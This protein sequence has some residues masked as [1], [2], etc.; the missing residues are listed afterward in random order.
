MRSKYP[1]I[2][3]RSASNSRKENL[4]AAY[5]TH[6]QIALSL[7][8]LHLPHLTSLN[9]STTRSRNPTSLPSAAL[10]SSRLAIRCVFRGPFLL[11]CWE[12]S[13]GDVIK[14][15]FM[16]E[17]LGENETSPKDDGEEEIAGGEENLSPAIHPVG[18][19]HQTLL[20]QRRQR[21]SAVAAR[22]GIETWRIH[23]N[24]ILRERTKLSQTQAWIKVE[25]LTFSTF[26]TVVH[27]KMILFFPHLAP[28]RSSFTGL[29]RHHI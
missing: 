24:F 1:P 11:P 7:L 2:C 27:L 16:S 14:R 5:V 23:R 4:T 9:P 20:R 29:R 3:M 18:L 25:T 6:I 28:C 13:L 22:L 8:S 12:T 17:C 26:V 19:D 21:T 10:M 15:L